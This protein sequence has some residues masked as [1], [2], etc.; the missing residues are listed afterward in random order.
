[1]KW[2]LYHLYYL[3]FVYFLKHHQSTNTFERPSEAGSVF[4]FLLI[5]ESK[6]KVS[7]E[8]KSFGWNLKFYFVELDCLSV[9]A[10]SS[11][12]FHSRSVQR[13]RNA[14]LSLLFPDF[15]W[16]KL[17]VI[18]HFMQHYTSPPPK[19]LRL[20]S[21]SCKGHAHNAEQSA[22]GKLWRPALRGANHISTEMGGLITRASCITS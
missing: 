19:S 1:M 4:F 10:D 9:F 14:T 12:R 8:M 11:Q 22:D 17:V 6:I 7:L 16:G 3:L 20:L 21:I 5:K 18:C 15:I 13:D 2:W